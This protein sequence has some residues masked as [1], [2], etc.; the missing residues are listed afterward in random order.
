MAD[1]K[2]TELITVASADITGSEIFPIVHSGDTK[3]TT[4]LAVKD[5]VE[6]NITGNPVTGI[7]LNGNTLTV[8]LEDNSTFDAD[9]TALAIDTNTD[10]NTTVSSGV[11]DANL[12]ILTM[13]DGS[14]VD[15]PVSSLLVDTNTQLSD[16]DIA[17]LGYIKTDTNTQLTDSDIASLGY[18]KSYTNTQLSDSDIAAFGYV[19]N[20]QNTQL[21]DADIT[22]L[23]YI[24]TDTNTQLTDAEIT[25]LGYIKTYT[26]T[27]LTDAD[28]AA[29]GYI[30]TDTNTQLSDADIAALGYVK[31]DTQLTDAEIGAFGYTKTD[32]NTQ[33]S[34]A[35]IAAFGY[36]KTDT[37]LTDAEITALGYV[38]TDNDTQ[39]SDAD[40]AALGYAKTSSLRTIT[41]AE[42]ETLSHFEYDASQDQLVAD[43]AIETTLNS[44]F[45]G[46]QHKMSSGSENIFFTN[47][48]SDINFFPMWGGLK[49]QSI[50]A[51]QGSDGYIPPSGRVYTDMFSLPLG[52]SPV[53]STSIG[54]SGDNYF[55]I[56][57]AGLGITTVAAEAIDQSLVRLDYKISINSRQV[58]KQTL[59]E[60]AVRAANTIAA[61]DTIE[62]FFDH[63]VDVRAGT[64][65]FAEIRKIRKSDDV[66][67]GVFQVRKGDTV[68]PTSG[69]VRYQST[70]H[71][72]LFEDKDLEFASPNLSKTAM[73]FGLDS[74]GS[75]ILLRDLSLGSD[76][77][78]E[79]HAVNTLEAIASGTEIKI[80]VKD[81]AKVVVTALSVSSTS[82]NGSFVNSVLNQAVV[83][84]NAI[85]TNTA[86]FASADKFVNSFSLIGD[87]LT[88]GLNDGTSFTS[89]VTTFGVDEN[90]FVSSAT[91]NGNI[92]TLTMNDATSLL[93]DAASLA[94]D[95][96]TTITGGSVSGTTL[97]LNTSSGSVI[98]IDASG[99]AGG[100]SVASGSVVGTDLVLVMSD[101]ST[102]TIDAANM[103]NGASLSAVN[104]EWFISYGTN[105][106]N[107]VGETTMNANVNLQMPFYFGQALTRGAEFKFNI[108]SANQLRLGIWDGAAEATAFNGSPSAGDH[109]NWGT[110]F[111]YANGNGK[112]TSATNTDISTY[113]SG[114]YSVTDS[115]PM[116]IRFGNDGHLTLMDLSGGTE[117]IVGK[118]LIPL[119]VQSFNMQVAGW[120]NT[121]FPNAIISDSNFLWEIVHDYTGTEAGV[122]NGILN[123]TV[124]KRNLALSP[125]EQYMIP[126]NKQGGGETFGIG[127]S[128]AAT[129]I[130]TAEDDLFTSFKY[131]TNESIIADIS[132]NH[133]TSS[134]RYFTAGVI[135]SWREGGAGTMQGLFSL[136]YL[137][138][139]TLQIWSET[140]NELV[141]SSAVHPDGSDINLY[142]GA[143]GNTNYA[144]L[145]DI[146]KQFIGQGS[147]PLPS[148]Q[149]IAANQ[150]ASV[151]EGAVLNFQVV[152]SDNIVNQF[153]EV[154]APSWM[155][156]NQTTGVLS[157]TAPAFA[158]TSA[159]TIVVNCK[160]GN[161]IGG[162][163]DFTVTV[164]IT[165][166]T[167][168]GSLLFPASNSA[169]FLTGNASNI[170]ALQRSGNGTGSSDAWSIS[171]WVKPSANTSSQA[172]FYYGGNNLTTKGA[173]QISQFSGG[174]AL[175]RF[176]DGTDFVAYFGLGNFTTGSWNHILVTYSGAD[177][178]NANG[179]ASAFT[180]S[181]N[182]ANGISQIQAGGAGYSGSVLDETF[183]VGSHNSV[184]YLKGATVH[185]VAIW[186]SDQSANLAT[187]YNSGATQD[188]SL[189]SPAPAHILQPTNSV[190]TI[191]DSVGNADL[192]GFG[193]TAAAL[194]TDAP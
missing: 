151:A 111:S 50:V 32:N 51:N 22:A 45:L 128:G 122:L 39:L 179:G 114:G 101:A 167:G 65:I 90:K 173:I 40:I 85:F 102:V 97:N 23:G 48:T 28:I 152:T 132:W 93:I 116:S 92:I 9:V 112:F 43:R 144:S 186:D 129:G 30:K 139:N 148:F 81:G 13:S 44:L 190:T 189:L 68:D 14:T 183:K 188:L 17:A 109:T 191:P 20:D 137:T 181:I 160:A 138:D 178:I 185:Q 58:Y 95:N 71:N 77:V 135:D 37:Q 69:L 19:K 165:E 141:A 153:A 11:V 117:V 166:V 83:Q 110:V 34:D 46:E 79:S 62:W 26:D 150:T 100:V 66:D 75:T 182:G 29:L 53:T 170:S 184:N 57:I 42:I 133:N 61:G 16:S 159:D 99:L 192:T 175:F 78:I 154:D 33:L 89:D 31:T 91:L 54:Y 143:N 193:F 82:I 119:S 74:T 56:N 169:A 84:L 88:L 145:P 6:T 72:R 38:K 131:Q 162:T 5:Y 156:L 63:P 161:A 177:T 103:V 80:K 136:R 2:I 125:G 130:I 76:N 187:I 21:T 49:D 134:S 194:V 107:P 174:N 3:Q 121:E 113:H 126:L 55:G 157:G 15:I 24:K 4:L 171:M 67:L 146:T 1:K 18:I 155:T 10:T 98:A 127:Y 149:P 158:G 41:A 25:S 86:G 124:L 59:P 70:V 36:V 47:L 64:T 94:I 7:A 108:D 106:N 168:G 12:L 164:T 60:N 52:G 104:N 140:Y 176:G 115:A 123:H 172:L 163:V 87:D 96:D 118:T 147:Q 120:N 35:D 73:D 180:F 27:Q 105:A 142:F 8:T